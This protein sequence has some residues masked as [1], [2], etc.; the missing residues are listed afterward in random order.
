MVDVL[1]KT[2][3]TIMGSLH[4]GSHKKD[5]TDQICQI[6]LNGLRKPEKDVSATWCNGFYI[7]FY[8]GSS[9]VFTG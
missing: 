7:G 9:H 8:K 3:F 5:L 4:T 1:V 6:R 2:L